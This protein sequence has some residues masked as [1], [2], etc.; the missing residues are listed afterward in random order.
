M[1]KAYDFLKA[2]GVFYVA[3]VNKGMPAVRPFGAIMELDGVMYICTANVKEVYK[4]ML[5]CPYIQLS[6]TKPATHDWIRV[7]A[8]A[9]EKKDMALK[10]AMMKAC[11]N[12]LNIYQSS[13]NPVFTVFALTEVSGTLYVD[14]KGTDF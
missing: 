4:E 9:V 3:T 2:N 7:K 1:S 13:T 6:S 12:L 14:N 10:E 11:P 8:K 5:E